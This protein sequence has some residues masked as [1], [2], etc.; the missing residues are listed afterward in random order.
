MLPEMARNG[1]LATLHPLREAH[2]RQP[3]F[4]PRDARRVTTWFVHAHC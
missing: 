4:D 2:F 1:R 3:I